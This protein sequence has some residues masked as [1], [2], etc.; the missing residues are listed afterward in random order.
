MRQ[1]GAAELT[2]GCARDTILR[3][4]L[5]ALGVG[6]RTLM[7]NIHRADVLTAAQ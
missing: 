1:L 2:V 3:E 7:K 6:E 4:I 5:H